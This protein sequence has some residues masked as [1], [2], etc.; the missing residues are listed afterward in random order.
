MSR[1]NDRDLSDDLNGPYVQASCVDC[2][3]DVVTDC[4]PD[5][6]LCDECEDKRERWAE[7]IAV[8]MAKATLSNAAHNMRAKGQPPVV[9]DVAIVPVSETHGV[10]EVALRRLATA[11]LQ[12]DLTTIKDVA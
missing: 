10:V 3:A 1:D 11:V 6:A 8:R 7:Q 2:G 12:A 4:D 9:V 5:G